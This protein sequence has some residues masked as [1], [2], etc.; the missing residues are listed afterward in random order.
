MYEVKENL[1]SG[2]GK[3]GSMGMQESRECHESRQIFVK[4]Y[5]EINIIFSLLYGEG[6]GWG[7]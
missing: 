4:N 7:K 1:V 6:I 5:L 3:F 2:R